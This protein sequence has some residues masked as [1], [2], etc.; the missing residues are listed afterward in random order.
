MIYKIYEYYI[1]NSVVFKYI[2][3]TFAFFDFYFEYFDHYI[4]D[5]I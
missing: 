2:N 3:F 5:T 1:H 4:Y